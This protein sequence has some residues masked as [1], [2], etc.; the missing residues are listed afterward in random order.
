MLANEGVNSYPLILSVDDVGE[1]FRVSA[2][3]PRS[4]GAQRVLG[5]VCTALA[6]LVGEV[7]THSARDDENVPAGTEYSAAALRLATSI[8]RDKVRFIECRIPCDTCRAV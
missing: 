7:L 6:G 4:V 1:D 2:L 3:A 8:R 5:Y